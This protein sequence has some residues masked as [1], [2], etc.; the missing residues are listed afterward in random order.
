MLRYGWLLCG[1]AFL[2]SGCGMSPP[3]S[4]KA[5]TKAEDGYP[6]WIGNYG[7][8]KKERWLYL[9]HAPK[10]IIAYHQNHIEAIC[11]MHE[12]TR[13]VAAQGRFV[14]VSEEDLEQQQEIFSRIPYYG[15]HGIDQEMAVWLQPDMILGWAS[16]FSGRG[17][18]SL[19]TIDFWEK[20]GTACYMSG[21][22]KDGKVHETIEDECR[23]ISNM[24]QIFDKQGQAES[25]LQDI[26]S[27]LQEGEK[28]GK[29]E[30]RQRVLILDFYN[31]AVVSYG[32]NR[33]PG[34]MVKRLGGEVIALSER[35]SKEEILM[36]DP[37]AIFLIYK[38]NGDERIREDFLN[39][40]NFESLKAVRNRRVYPL[41]I[42]YIYNSGSRVKD[43]LLRIK[44]G[45][46][47]L[48]TDT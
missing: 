18:W 26:K 16:S 35:L 6:V 17:V 32:E 47:P 2:M 24:G 22:W 41:P 8:D 21:A 3:V 19:G 38:N 37:D 5:E 14:A 30:G 15:I 11:R 4:S 33:L 43:G 36:A 40:R 23:Y 42:T 9:R 48:K 34:D 25:L 20:R 28:L 12:E 31:S 27:I 46:Y 29:T 44:E 45:L 7:M 39:D 13:I 10:R 1:A